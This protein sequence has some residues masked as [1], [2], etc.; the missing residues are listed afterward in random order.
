MKVVVQRVSQAS[1]TIENEIKGEISQ[2]LMVLVG[3]NADDTIN[4]V[5]WMCNKILGLRIFSDTDDKMNLSLTDI[6]GGILLISNFTLY[7]DAKKGNRPNF[8]AAARPETAIPLY[9][10]MLN[11][12][13]KSNLKIESG[14]FG[15]M[16]DVKLIN[17]GP[18]TIIIEK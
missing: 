16:M 6:K 11:E 3:F 18:V 10:F 2:G 12:L 4:E 17:D 1:V 5:K 8:S 14:V 13:K 15:A 7:G 9:D